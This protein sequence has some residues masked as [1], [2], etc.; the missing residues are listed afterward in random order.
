[1]YTYWKSLIDHLS[2]FLLIPWE[3]LS[4]NCF[5]CLFVFERETEHTVGGTEREGDTE[6]D[7]LQALSCQ[8]KARL[9]VL[10]HTQWD[11]DL[12]PSQTQPIEPPR[13]PCKGFLSL[14]IW[15]SEVKSISINFQDYLLLSL[16]LLLLFLVG[17]LKLHN[18]GVPGWLSQLSTRL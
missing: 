7:R 6:S 16:L 4:F 10:T 14:E 13:L 17:N 15:S 2:L 18:I 12:S 8:H 9:R 5:N 11:H 3:F 1:M